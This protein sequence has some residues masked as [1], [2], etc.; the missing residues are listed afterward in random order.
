LFGIDSSTSDIV[1]I[2]SVGNEMK[3]KIFN[4]EDPDNE[5][6]DKVSDIITFPGLNVKHGEKY[7]ISTVYVK[8]KKISCNECPNSPPNGPEF[9]DMKVSG[10]GS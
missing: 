4:A 7:H 10:K 1:T 2:V 5:D 9:A 8:S 6:V 3:A